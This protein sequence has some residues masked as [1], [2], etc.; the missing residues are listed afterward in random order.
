MTS[1]DVLRAVTSAFGPS[2]FE[3]EV[4]ETIRGLVAAFVDETRV[5]ALGN[6]FALRPNDSAPVLM[7]EAHMDEIGFM[8]SHIHDDGFLRFVPLG[9]WDARILP[10]HCVTIRTREGR[11]VKGIIGTVPPHLTTEQERK[12]PA[13][14]DSL[15][16]DVA[17]QSGEDVAAMGIRIGDPMTIVYP[18]EE[19]SA[20]TIMAKALDDR[21][22]CAVLIRVMEEL[23]GQDLGVS[24]ACVFTVLEEEG[25]KGAKTA[26]FGLDPQIALSVEGTIEA[27]VPGVP[28]QRQPTRLGRGPAISVADKTIVVNPRMV[29]ALEAAAERA[30]VDYQYKTPRFGGT[31][32][33][34]I[35]QSRA[36]V[37]TGVLSVP[38]R[39]IHSPFGIL[40]L[41][42]FE[43]TVKTAVEFVRHAAAI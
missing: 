19:L 35:H 8:V 37:L 43:A 4:R 7:I 20:D 30:G 34:A 27:N 41:G 12:K 16:V 3:D 5:D 38:C 26:A 29:Q 32:A 11:R 15:F 40:R 42:D 28:D 39:Y 22:G 6:L 13:E 14:I 18:F 9:G 1:K 23:R 17:A 25:L 10:S 36:G 33:G 21:A 24:L 2:G 31:N